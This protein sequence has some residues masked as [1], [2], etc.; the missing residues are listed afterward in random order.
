[1]NTQ[2]FTDGYMH[3]QAIDFP[4]LGKRTLQAVSP[5][6][7]LTG[8]AKGVSQWVGRRA[9]PNK[10]S[11]GDTSIDY[12]A[13]PRTGRTRQTITAYRGSQAEPRNI[14]GNLQAMPARKGPTPGAAFS[15]TDT[16]PIRTS[17]RGPKL[18]RDQIDAFLSRANRR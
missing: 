12:G 9:D 3:K 17:T 11:G 15:G 4:S 6:A 2:A 7:G 1:M 16:Y 8:A 10:G 5:L 18:T 14:R 13:D